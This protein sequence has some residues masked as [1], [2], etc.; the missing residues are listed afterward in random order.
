MPTGIGNLLL[1]GL[2]SRDYPLI[3][4]VVIVYTTLFVVVNLI[5]DLCYAASDPRIRLAQ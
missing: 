5:V 1:Q 4:G 3:T 2:T